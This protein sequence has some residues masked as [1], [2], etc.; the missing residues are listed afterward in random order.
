[1][2]RAGI[3]LCGLA[4]HESES[5]PPQLVDSLLIVNLHRHL[6][7]PCSETPLSMVLDG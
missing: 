2:N 1:M 5:E 6:P 3:H 7:S 4:E